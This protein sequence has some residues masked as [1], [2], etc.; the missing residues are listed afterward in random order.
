MLRWISLHGFRSYTELTWT[1]EP[2][3]NVLVGDNG[4]GKT[5]LLEAVAYLATLRSF[6]GSPDEA[7]IQSGGEVAVV[8]GEAGSGDQSH[9]IELEVPRRGRRRVRLDQKG[10]Q[11]TSH[12][13]EVMKVVT[14]LPEDLELA[15]GGPQAR[16][17]LIDDLAAQLWPAAEL[18]QAELDRALRQRNAFLRAGSRDEVTLEVWDSRLAQAAGRV[19]L[20]RA[21]A[22]AAIAGTLSENY[23][24]VAGREDQVGLG[25]E[26]EWGGSLDPT[27]PP[28]EWE[29]ALREALGRRRRADWETG[30]TGAGPHR[31]DVT[32]FIGPRPARHQASQGE[33]R[34][35]ALALRLASHTAISEATK[36]V[37]LL[38]LDD[39]FSELDHRRA[40]LLTKALPTAQT[41]V[42][43]TRPE[44]VP[45]EGTVW[46]VEPGAVR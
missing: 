2:G 33:Q 21:R 6:R 4:S 36:L 8:R 9:L 24:L 16:R 39:V 38:L 15:K 27:T 13:R 12:L 31:D 46:R 41:L 5:N 26:S 1:P 20:R 37:P 32:F 11:R 7:L 19:M 34:T 42:T 44:E 29:Q 14:F 3:T 43:T 35:L 28:S 45:V 22:A 30:T 18:D 23:S 17:D 10:L 25:Y 40:G